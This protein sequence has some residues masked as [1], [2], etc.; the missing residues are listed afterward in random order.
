SVYFQGFSLFSLF[1]QPVRLAPCAVTTRTHYREFSEAG[2]SFFKKKN[3]LLNSTA[4]PPL[5]R[6][7]QQFY[8]QNIFLH[9]ISMSNANVCVIIAV[10]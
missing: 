7:Y 9:K 10:D 4:K 8:P 3:R 5:I 1:S 2:N 6:T